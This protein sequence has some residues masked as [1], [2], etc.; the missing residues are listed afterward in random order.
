MAAES[1]LPKEPIAVIEVGSS[2]IRMVIAEIG[3]K[4]AL[5]LLENLQKPVAFGKDVFTT[6]RLSPPAIRQ[7][8]D[9]LEHFKSMLESYG[10]R[11]WSAIATSAI[12]EATNKENF[13]DQV[14]VRTGIDV[15][16]IET[17][18]ENRLELIAV[19]SALA[20]RFEFDKKNCLI[21][22]V[23]TGSTEVILTTK[24]EVTL[25]RML[26]I[27]PLR[28]PDHEAGKSDPATLQ[29]ALK[30][31]VHAIAEDF[32]RESNFADVNSFI[33]LGSTMRFLCRQ[34]D[35]QPDQKLATLSTKNFQDFLKIA[36]KLSPDELSEKYGLPYSDAET[37]YSSL[38][39]YGDF[40][41]EANA[42]PIL[43]PMVSIRDGLLIEM[44]QLVSGYKRTD[45]SKQVIHSAKN[46]AK[47]YKTDDV[48]ATTVTN[49]ALK[50]FDSLKEDHLLGSRERL[51][52][53]V[54]AVLH[55]VGMFISPSSH[56]KHAWYLI[57]AS[58]IFGLRKIDKDIVANVVRY[59]RRSP[60]KLT[61]VPYASL[62]RA[63]RA[64]VSKLASILRVADALDTSRQQKCK[65]FTLHQDGD[66]CTVWVPEAA[67]DITLERQSLMKKSDMLTDVL[68]I[69][70]QLK[71]GTVPVA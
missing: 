63:E 46:L 2:A 37:L 24:G 34:Y 47:K 4:M 26:P 19:E 14:Y 69:T 55:D 41:A 16:V 60:P 12:R 11:R 62:P 21:I 58:D 68:G 13:V 67:G 33:A 15:E 9:I 61:H 54:S 30:R 20:G 32:R 18:E 36:A 38:L 45:L 8:I 59:H 28:M 64:V 40:L 25:T 6:G 22:E 39:I 65:D 5:R 10:V 66:V 50:L 52:L 31:R 3:P 23:G 29:R 27:G 71:Q 56:H 17:A 70:I 1:P 53:E 51:L 7:G 43:V 44:A 42:D 49:I 48:H 57:E 35:A